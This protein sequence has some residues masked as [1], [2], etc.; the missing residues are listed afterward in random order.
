MT[1]QYTFGMLKLERLTEV[2]A[3]IRDVFNKYEVIDYSDEGIQEFM[4]FIEP[5]AI[6][7]M[8]TENKL[9]ITI[10]QK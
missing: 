4:R 9:S 7:E 10:H 2:L 3:L 6:K 8:W 1:A 5:E